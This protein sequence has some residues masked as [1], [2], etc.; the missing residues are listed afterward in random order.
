V[1]SKIDIVIV[2][3]AKDD[4]CKSLTSR[5]I[6]TLFSSEE[7]SSEIFNVIVVESQEGVTWNYK[8]C[9]IQ[10]LSAPLP[11]GYHKFLNFGRKSGSSEWVALCNNDLEFTKNWFSTIL[12]CH[13]KNPDV[14]SFSPIC[15][16]TQVMYGI[17]PHSGIRF[18]HNIRKELSG[19]CI[20]HKREIYD[21]IGDLDE[22]FFHWFCD[23]DYAMTLMQQG[24]KHALVTDSIV[25]HHDK[26][27]GKTTEAVVSDNTEMFR[28]TTGSQPIF[29]EKWGLL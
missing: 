9:N 14:I 21:I 24:L 5:C 20:V 23:N 19:W 3:Y 17:Y 10:T 8:N 13:E 18:G 7:N 16:M 15:P 12:D 27:I 2:S 28:L 6:E 1:D 25:I 29:L 22:R 11:Y 26:N 4:Y